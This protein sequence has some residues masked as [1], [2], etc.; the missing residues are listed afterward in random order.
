ML[1]KCSPPFPHRSIRATDASFPSLAHSVECH[2]PYLFVAPIRPRAIVVL[3]YF[4]PNAELSILELGLSWAYP[5]LTQLQSMAPSTPTLE[6]REAERRAALYGLSKAP[7]VA[8]QAADARARRD[9]ALLVERALPSNQ[10]SDHD[11]DGLDEPRHHPERGWRPPMDRVRPVQ[12][13]RATVPTARGSA[14][15]SPA[16]RLGALPPDATFEPIALYARQRDRLALPAAAI[17]YPARLEPGEQQQQ[18]QR[19]PSVSADTAKPQWRPASSS[20]RPTRS[21]LPTAHQKFPL[22]SKPVV[23]EQ[24]EPHEPHECTTRHQ[25]RSVLAKAV[26]QCAALR[27]KLD[28]LKDPT[29]RY[30]LPIEDGERY[31]RAQRLGLDAPERSTRGEF[32]PKSAAAAAKPKLEPTVAGARRRP[33]SASIAYLR[34]S[35]VFCMA[36]G[37]AA[38]AGRALE[39]ER[40]R[41]AE[42]RD[43]A[44][45]ALAQRGA[46]RHVVRAQAFA[47]LRAHSTSGASMA[48]RRELDGIDADA[49]LKLCGSDRSVAAR[50]LVVSRQ[51]ALAAL[52]PLGAASRDVHA[53]YSALDA[54]V[55]DRVAV[56][57]LLAAIDELQAAHS[58]LRRRRAEKN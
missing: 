49:F 50:A 30:A 41:R 35:T 17:A 13:L 28:R 9:L 7:R 46:L 53:L 20:A 4:G 54:A 3:D 55:A 26:E 52:E 58:A 5:H 8:V 10:D 42:D 14:A 2:P 31:P 37:A 39:L 21:P 47:R 16:W 48:A 36:D 15:A 40:A 45:L 12:D 43:A 33:R 24:H 38:D 22:R 51:Q 27:K 6:R 57:E 25:H 11:V 23:D 32:R 18:Q 56:F 34:R 29:E 19:S 44:L 1:S